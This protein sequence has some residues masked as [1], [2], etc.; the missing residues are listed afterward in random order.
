MTQSNRHPKELWYIA[1]S[2]AFTC[3]CFGLI[4]SLLVLYL[5]QDLHFSNKKAYAIFAA[6]FSLIYALP[7]IGG[8][9]SS[10]FG[11]KKGMFWGN[12]ILIGGLFFLMTPHPDTVYLGLAMYATGTAI[13][14]P[15]YLTMQGKLYAK[16]DHRRESAYTLSYVIT[17]VGFLIAAVAGGLIQKY[18]SFQDCFLVGEIIAFVPLFIFYF[19]IRPI[20]AFEGRSIAPLTKLSNPMAFLGLIVITAIM[21]PVCL[22]LL[23][24]AN[25]NNI[26][27]IILACVSVSIIIY[28]ALTRKNARDKKRL[29]VFIILSVISIGFW[30]MYSLEPSLLTIFIKTNVDRTLFNF[31]IPPSIFYGLDPFYIITFGL[32]LSFLWLR[33]RRR[34]KDPSLQAKFTMS[35]F[36][37][38]IGLMLLSFLIKH[39][40]FETKLS[41]WWIVLVY[42]FL[43][44]AELLIS[45]I[46]QAMV[47]RLSPEGFEGGLMGVWQMFSGVAAAISGF[48]AQW[49]VVPK[50]T[51]LAHSN[52]VYVTGFFRIGMIA[53]TLAVVSLII[54]PLI[55]KAMQ[56]K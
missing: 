54:M 26:L 50:H 46:G 12:I 49:A 38:V 51:S 28:L 33:L 35:L 39:H 20:K 30:S 48:M 22:F 1:T 18:L 5:T 4:A 2:A 23:Q 37:L 8:Y 9:L 53:L 56:Q 15:T 44:A 45:P 21:I 19:L 17:N 3:M 40:G 16:N 31:T 27:L 29:F 47:G 24:H 34:K 42:F 32:F 41:M 43:T 6:Y 11:F 36:A 52:P 25:F 7:V 13:Y 55:K 14:T 10:Y